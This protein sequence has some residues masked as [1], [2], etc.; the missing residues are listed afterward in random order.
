MKK[1]LF[2]AALTSVALASCVSDE[3]PAI[4]STP[5]DKP[6]TFNSPIIYGMTRAVS[7][8]QPSESIGGSYYYSKDERFRVYAQWT[9]DKLTSWASGKKYMNNVETTYQT[10]TTSNG[11]WMPTTAY[12]WPKNGYLRFSAYSP[13]DVSSNGTLTF[14]GATGLKI[15][16]YTTPAEGA[17]YDF[18]YSDRTDYKQGPSSGTGFYEGVDITF[19]HALSSI[20]FLVKT[21]D[22][23][24]G[25]TIILK[26]VKVLN[27]YNKATFEEKVTDDITYVSAP[28]WNTYSDR[29]TAGYVLSASDQVVTA[30]E[31]PVNGTQNPLLLIPQDLK[32][33]TIDNSVKIQVNYSI[34]SSGGDE[35]DQQYTLNLADTDGNGTADYQQGTEGGGS[36]YNIVEWEKGKRYIYTIVIGLD[37]IY[38]NPKVYPWTDVTPSD[39]KI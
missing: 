18:M 4:D 32:G 24:T 8:E 35:I 7:G 37:K 9:Q 29:K 17:Q 26:S 28:E 14:E 10:E 39:I 30:T 15:A 22:T 6:I 27:P 36:S 5:G 33:A 1:F 20:K 21:L 23:Y 3:S 19:H 25:T 13:S 16:D 31:A 34:T 38:F 2:L 11:S 12:Y